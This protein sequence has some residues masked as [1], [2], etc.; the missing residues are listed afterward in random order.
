MNLGMSRKVFIDDYFE[1]QF[2]LCRQAFSNHGVEWKHVNEA[3]FSWD[4]RDD[5]CYG[6]FSMAK[7]LWSNTPSLFLM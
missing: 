6:Y 4:P 3:L 7:F 1:K 2:F 5:L